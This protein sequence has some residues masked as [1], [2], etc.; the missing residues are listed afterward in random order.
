[1]LILHV[2]L[3]ITM[4]DMYIYTCTRGRRGGGKMNRGE[5]GGGRGERWRV[6]RREDG[7]GRDQHSHSSSC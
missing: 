7:D 3:V 1:M 2:S 6:G 4:L 5:G